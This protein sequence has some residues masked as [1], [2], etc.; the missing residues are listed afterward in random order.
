MTLTL[1][2][3][4]LAV[5]GSGK[6]VTQ[7]RPVAP[8]HAVSVSAG[9]KAQLHRGATTKVTVRAD[10]NI[11][12]Q[13]ETVVKDGR[14]EVHPKGSNS[15]NNTTMEVDITVVGLDALE[16]S[17]GTEVKG[18]GLAG[19]KCTLRLS[20]GARVELSGMS[21]ERLD[22]DASGGAELKLAGSAK[23]LT[24]GASGGV[25]LETRSLDVK[26]AKVDASGGVT[27]RLAVADTLEGSLSGGV[28]LKVKGHPKSNLSASGSA[29]A[30]FED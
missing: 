24:L 2:A 18:D 17:G 19:A 25:A 30:T 10:D 23:Q 9:L 4:V 8:F 20:G 14:L 28:S 11:V 27:G 12:D 29:H 7:D 26:T 1:L 3:A 16:S 22:V 6:I 5:T 21:C 15:F 13:I